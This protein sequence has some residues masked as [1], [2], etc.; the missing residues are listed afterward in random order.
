MPEEPCP[1]SDDE[2]EAEARLLLR[3]MIERSGWYPELQGKWREER[4]GQDVERHWHL[5]ISEARKRLE[6]RQ[7]RGHQ[8][9]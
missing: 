5:M 1:L 9:L 4:I 3:E 8:D 7:V 2:V 6:Q